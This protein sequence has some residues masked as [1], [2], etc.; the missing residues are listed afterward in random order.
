[1]TTGMTPEDITPSELSQPQI[2]TASLHSGEMSTVAK[3]TEA[4]SRMVVARE[5][6]EGEMGNCYSWG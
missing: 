1:M 3:F 2:N 4:D 5:W 6:A